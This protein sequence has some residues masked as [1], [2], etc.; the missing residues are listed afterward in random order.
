M[1]QRKEKERKGPGASRV[2]VMKG[3]KWERWISVPKGV[4][5]AVV[6]GEE[7]ESERR[8]ENG[9]ASL[10]LVAKMMKVKM[11]AK[12]KRE[13]A[14]EEENMKRDWDWERD[15]KEEGECFDARTVAEETS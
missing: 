10:G 8:S 12:T 1:E 13:E 2:D 11:K 4:R 9:N 3:V 7:G 5:E 15:W 14:R 6:E